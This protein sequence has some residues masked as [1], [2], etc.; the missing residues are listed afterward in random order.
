MN[1]HD[2]SKQEG[3]ITVKDPYDI[4]KVI[5]AIHNSISRKQFTRNK[6]SNSVFVDHVRYNW[7]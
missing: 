1:M 6:V 4:P 7:I 2:I 3:S 5:M